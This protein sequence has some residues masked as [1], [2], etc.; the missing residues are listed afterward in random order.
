ML[1]AAAREDAPSVA[2]GYGSMERLLKEPNLECALP[3]AFTVVISQ[4]KA[5]WQWPLGELGK[6]RFVVELS[7][8]GKIVGTRFAEPS[9]SARWVELIQRMTRLLARGRF[10][11]GEG[12]LERHFELSLSHVRHGL[13]KSGELGEIEDMGAVPAGAV[14][15]QRVRALDRA[16]HEFTALLR[17]L[18]PADKPLAASQVP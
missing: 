1:D 14:C 5:Y 18:G 4:E 2:V 17:E 3:R 13:G 7:N 10:E 6:P 11:V 9:P 16:G 12:R 15:A 8:E